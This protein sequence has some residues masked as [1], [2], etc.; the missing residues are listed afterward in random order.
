[1]D[2]LTVSLQPY[3]E[4]LEQFAKLEA[5]WDSYD[6]APIAGDAI[7][8]AARLLRLVSGFGWLVG[9]AALPFA[10]ALSP[11]GGIQVE[12]CR[13]KAEIEVRVNP[14]GTFGYLHIEKGETGRRFDEG[15][16]TPIGQLL[17]RI[18][19]TLVP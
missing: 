9:D 13:P 8:R 14:D 16:G 19:R 7:D 11:D 2:D 5:N 6:A 12:W 10:V 3:F 1:V 18:L 4:R 15:E 17:N